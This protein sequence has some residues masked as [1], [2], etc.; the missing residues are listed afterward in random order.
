VEGAAVRF[1]GL[2]FVLNDAGSQT[3]A[4]SLLRIILPSRRSAPPHARSQQHPPRAQGGR[5][6][7]GGSCQSRAYK[8]AARSLNHDHSYKCLGFCITFIQPQRS[9]AHHHHH[10]NHRTHAAPRPQAPLA[11]PI[12]TIRHGSSCRCLTHRPRCTQQQTH[13]SRAS[14]V[15]SRRLK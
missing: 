13:R 3:Y 5:G 1:Q 7:E 11:Q 8:V 14:Q 12:E 9:R 2:W 10:H 6:C 4:C 15:Q